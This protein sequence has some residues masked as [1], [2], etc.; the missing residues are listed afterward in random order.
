VAALQHAATEHARLQAE[1][2]CT[3]PEECGARLTERQ[4]EAE[5]ALRL[6]EERLVERKAGPLK[7]QLLRTVMP[8]LTAA[9]LEVPSPYLSVLSHAVT[10]CRC[11]ARGRRTRWTLW[12]VVG[13]WGKP[14]AGC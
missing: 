14:A 13:R 5:A 6:E 12:C 11:A 10:L 7:Q 2:V 8:T 1:Q 4:A 3:H 9:L